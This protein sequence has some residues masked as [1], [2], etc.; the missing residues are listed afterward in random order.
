MS[1][2][3]EIEQYFSERERLRRKHRVMTMGE[4]MA[5]TNGGDA[6]SSS[7]V[8]NAFPGGL[9]ILFNTPTYLGKVI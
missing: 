2:E 8:T 9:T 1:T 6:L 5:W 7:G 4:Y 3:A